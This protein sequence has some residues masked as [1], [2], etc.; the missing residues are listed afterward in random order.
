MTKK[1]LAGMFAL[2]MAASAVAVPVYAA[3]STVDNGEAVVAQVGKIAQ[4]KKFLYRVDT[5]GTISLLK[6]KKAALNSKGT[7]TIPAKIGGKPVVNM[8]WGCQDFFLSNFNKIKVVDLPKTLETI[9]SMS[10]GYGYNNSTNAALDALN[11]GGDSYGYDSAYRGYYKRNQKV[12]IKC[13]KNSGGERYAINNGLRY[14]YKDSK[15]LTAPIIKDG[16]SAGASAVKMSWFEVSG[17]SGYQV[18]QYDNSVGE[19]KVIKTIKGKSKTS[20][21]LTG[22]KKGEYAYAIRAYKNVSG[23]KQYSQDS[24]TIWYDT[25]PGKATIKKGKAENKGEIVFTMPYK[26]YK[27][28]PGNWQLQ[29]Y[30]PHLKKWCGC[31]YSYDCGD[32]SDNATVTYRIDGCSVENKYNGHYYYDRL[33]SGTKYKVRIRGYGT[34][35]ITPDQFKVIYGDWSN[36]LTIKAK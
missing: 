8:E 7:V 36:K 30:V 24:Y 3:D 33:T 34:V 17:A 31:Y 20:V 4:N 35:K 22:M 21:K 6:I 29:I 11:G 19:E 2:S 15:E 9:T 1:L 13:Y 28:S 26:T 12:K 14:V 27:Q 32:Y 25:K 5:N 18:M 23:G 16:S 10:I